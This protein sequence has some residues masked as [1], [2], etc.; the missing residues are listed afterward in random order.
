[1]KGEGGRR[2]GAKLT[3]SA[4]YRQVIRSHPPLGREE[5]Q[6]LAVRARNGDVIA[7]RQLVCHNLAFVLA[8]A[9]RQQRGTL[10]LDDLVQEGNLGLIRAADKF[11]P[12]VGTRFSTYAIWWIRAF[13]GKYLKEARSAVRPRGG[14]VA[15]ADLSLD[16]PVGDEDEPTHLDR[17]EDLGPSPEDACVVAETGRQVRLALDRAHR[18]MGGLGWDIVHSRLA[19]QSPQTLQA[20]GR[21]WSVSRERVRQV[22]SKTKRLL[23]RYLKPSG[24]EDLPTSSD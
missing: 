5:E 10:S 9:Q 7:K 2:S 8:I 4:R 23:Q 15:Q 12:S 18:R 6:A 22:E 20:L 11:D 16:T 14:A 13:I 3:V 21:R 1:M 24:E 19:Q 17:L